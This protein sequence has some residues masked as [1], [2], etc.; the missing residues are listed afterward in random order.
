MFRKTNLKLS[1][2]EV[3]IRFLQLLL[4]TSPL[5]GSYF[6]IHNSY[7]SPFSCPILGFTGIPC[8]S[9]GLTRSFF[10]FSQGNLFQSF[11]YHLFGPFIYCNLIIFS[12][13]LFLEIYHQ[14]K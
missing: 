1:T 13:H 10:A 8:P 4:L 5:I 9:C 6:F 7:N 14:K 3:K 2:F 11:S 12:L